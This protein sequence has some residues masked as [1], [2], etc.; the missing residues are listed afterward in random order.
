MTIKVNDLLKN[1]NYIEYSGPRSKIINIVAPLNEINGIDNA[2]C[3]CSDKNSL[4]LG[5]VKTASI[6]I[7]SPNM[8]KGLLKNINYIIVEKPRFTFQQILVNYFAISRPN[9]VQSS[10]I[11]SSSSVIGKNAYIGHNVVIEEGC[12]IG[13]NAIILNNTV[14]LDGTIIGHNVSIG[15]NNTIGG[16]GFG[17]EKNLEGD[18][19]LV[20]HIGNVL[21]KNNVDIGNN[22]CIDRAVLGSTI[23]EDNVKIDNLVHIAHGVVIGRNTVVIA[24][25]MVAGSVEIGENSW[26]APSASIINKTIIGSNSLVGLGAVV[27]KYVEDNSI[28][29]GN[30]AKFIRNIE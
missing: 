11:I 22:T 29:A 8:D 21:I 16:V 20:P 7:V 2:I 24:N 10:A 27:T 23:I 26:I 4:K 12:I 13:D 5:E 30:P 6:I 14:V 18:F 19:Q 15:C 1:I 9:K 17:Y 3:W 25:A 28:V